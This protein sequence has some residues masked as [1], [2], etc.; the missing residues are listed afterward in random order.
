[1]N[2]FVTPNVDFTLVDFE[3]NKN[4]YVSGKTPTSFLFQLF[5]RRLLFEPLWSK[6]NAYNIHPSITDS[7]NVDYGGATI[8]YSLLN[9][10]NDIVVNDVEVIGGSVTTNNSILDITNVGNTSQLTN[11]WLRRL[12]EN[13]LSPPIKSPNSFDL[14]I[15]AKD[16]EGS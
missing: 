4:N 6:T 10:M 8:D 15:S 9:G 3:K 12:V 5:D 2:K 14:D 11:P 7:D 13:P 1:M 16:E